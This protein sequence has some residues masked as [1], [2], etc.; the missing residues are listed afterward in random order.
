ML[1]PKVTE[2]EEQKKE[3]EEAA[4]DCELLAEEIRGLRAQKDGLEAFTKKKKNSRRKDR[5]D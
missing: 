5:P 1:V 3:A 2:A 4:G